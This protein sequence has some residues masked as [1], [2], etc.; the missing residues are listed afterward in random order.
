MTSCSIIGD[1]LFVDAKYRSEKVLD[2][3][4]ESLLDIWQKWRSVHRKKRS[5]LFV[6]P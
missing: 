4:V 1:L 3:K 2:L 6:L 5:F